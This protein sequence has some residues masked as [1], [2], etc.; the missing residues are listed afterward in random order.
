MANEGG[1]SMREISFFSAEKE[2]KKKSCFFS[3]S[4]QRSS[5]E[6]S[7]YLLFRAVVV[8]AAAALA[9]VV[10]VVDAELLHLLLFVCSP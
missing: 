10:A 9:E 7:V 3:P 2:R 6:F 4:A 8:A 1:E 5:F